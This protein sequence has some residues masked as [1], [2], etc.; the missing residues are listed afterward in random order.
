VYIL[1]YRI[2]G[3]V[4]GWRLDVGVFTFDDANY[5]YYCSLRGRGTRL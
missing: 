5:D 2:I 4:G 1:S 3:Y